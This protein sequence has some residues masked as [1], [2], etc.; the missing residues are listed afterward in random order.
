MHLPAR[1][2]LVGLFLLTCAPAAWA[3]TDRCGPDMRA[4][5]DHQAG[6]VF[7]YNQ[8]TTREAEGKR[9]GAGLIRKVRILRRIEAAES[10]AYEVEVR[11][12]RRTSTN[13]IPDIQIQYDMFREIQAYRDGPGN[14]FDACDGDTVSMP[15]RPETPEAFRTRVVLVK[16]DTSTFPLAERDLRMKYFGYELWTPAGL[17]VVDRYYFTR[18]AEGLGI[19]KMMVIGRGVNP[20]DSL[21]LIGYVKGGDT[22]GVVHPDAD[23]GPTT[24]L[25][26]GMPPRA[27]PA[28]DARILFD[29]LGR[30]RMPSAL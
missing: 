3:Q 15:E 6:D 4:L 16:G 10:L 19:V 20:F 12:R 24:A 1:P 17:P 11:E 18:Y 21:M 2:L 28:F 25:R 5:F 29:P 22:V 23:F 14:P 27:E 30:R 13:G 9:V 8:V 7:Q 26:P